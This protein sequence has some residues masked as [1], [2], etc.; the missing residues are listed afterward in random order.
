MLQL[1][2]EKERS[3]A[4]LSKLEQE[5][6]IVKETHEKKFLELESNAQKAKV[7]LEKQLKDSELRVVD[8]TEKAKELEKLCETKTKRWEKKEQRYK[9]FIN[10]QSEALQVNLT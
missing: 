7:E 6:E 1:K 3:N 10:H 2:K 8:S 5:L 9:R 4:Q